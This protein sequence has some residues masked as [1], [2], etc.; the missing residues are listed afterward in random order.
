MLNAR[1]KR[2]THRHKIVLNGLE[3]IL[4]LQN[5]DTNGLNFASLGC[6]EVPMKRDEVAVDDLKLYQTETAQL[7]VVS[8]SRKSPSRGVK[9]V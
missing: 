4:H 3:Q 1:F 8:K 7:D 5:V 2:S 6:F 9:S